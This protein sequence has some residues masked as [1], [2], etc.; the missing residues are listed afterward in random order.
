M[1]KSRCSIRMGCIQA[2]IFIK[3]P[4]RPQRSSRPQ[5]MFKWNPPD[6]TPGNVDSN[7]NV[8]LSN[9]KTCPP[10]EQ[11]N[12]FSCGKLTHAFLFNCKACLLVGQK[13]SCSTARHVFFST[14]R[15]VLVF[16]TRIC[17]LLTYR[18]ALQDD[19]SS[20]SK[21]RRGFWSMSGHVGFVLGKKTCLLFE[22][23]DMSSCP[24][25]HRM[26]SSEHQLSVVLPQAPHTL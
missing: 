22:L 4:K 24:H 5:N 20:C 15:H 8:F 23:E 10:V 12:M 1:D 13:D 2:L 9:K 11:E 21:E 18:L 7:F 19:M 25:G 26:G 6:A 16:S 3:S 14:G 17:L